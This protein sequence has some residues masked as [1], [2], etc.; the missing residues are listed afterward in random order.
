MH[1]GQGV[2]SRVRVGRRWL[3]QPFRFLKFQRLLVFRWRQI[4]LRNLALVHRVTSANRARGSCYTSTHEI[5]KL[6]TG[7]PTM[8][9]A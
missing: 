1:F 6:I 2:I 7:Q 3:S 5:E 9:A 4:W 8:A